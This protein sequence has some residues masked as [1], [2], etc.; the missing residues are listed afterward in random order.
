MIE[1]PACLPAPSSIR[2]MRRGMG[3]RRVA[4]SCL[5]RVGDTADPTR[6]RSGSAAGSGRHATETRCVHRTLHP[7]AP[8]PPLSRASRVVSLGSVNTVY[9]SKAHDACACAR[10]R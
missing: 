5:W 1:C 9:F 3:C 2:T 4:E 10:A 7:Q 6:P 8:L